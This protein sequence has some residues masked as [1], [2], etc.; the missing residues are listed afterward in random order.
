M[1]IIAFVPQETVDNQMTNLGEVKV[2]PLVQDEGKLTLKYVSHTQ[3]CN[4]GGQKKNFTS[5]LHFVCKR[6]ALVN[7]INI[8]IYIF[9]SLFIFTMLK[10]FEYF[11]YI[12]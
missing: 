5:V 10:R 7:L 9:I 12:I 11:V 1:K 6:G 3:D 8:F 2:G 4:D